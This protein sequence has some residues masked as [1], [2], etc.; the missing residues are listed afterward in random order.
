MGDKIQIRPE[1]IRPNQVVN[2]MRGLW[3]RGSEMDMKSSF[4]QLCVNASTWIMMA[5]FG[6]GHIRINVRIC[7]GICR[8]GR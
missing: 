3:R 5:I 4:V 7:D 1:L 2:P 8:E 6:L